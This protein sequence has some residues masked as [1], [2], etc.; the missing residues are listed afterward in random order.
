MSYIK[1]NKID[2]LGN[3]KI[4]YDYSIS[5]DLKKYFNLK[6]EYFIDYF[7]DIS[8]IPKAILTVP[9]IL[10]IIPLIW[11]TNS[12]LIID[13]IDETFYESIPSIKK[14][15][16][17]M[18]ENVEFKG[19]I[20]VNKIVNCNYKPTNRTATFFSGGLDS[21]STM[22]N[23]LD[24]KPDLVTLWGSDIDLEDIEGWNKVYQELK[25]IAQ[26][27][28]LKNVFIKSSFRK[29]INEGEL[30][31]S[32][33]NIL[34][35]N[36]WY[37]M[38]CGVGIIGH[39]APYAWKYKLSTQYIASS[40]CI[41]DGKVRSGSYPTIDNA[42]KFGSC[43]VYHD[44]FNYSRQDKTKYILK[45]CISKN[46]K[47]NLRVCWKST[48]GYNCCQCE[49]CYRTIFAILVEGN[50]P[51]DFGFDISKRDLKKIK[52][53]IQYTDLLLN[54][55][56]NKSWDEI[57]RAA[58]ENKEL[59]KSKLYYKDIKWIYNY[60]FINITDNWKY[61]L[62]YLKIILKGLISKGGV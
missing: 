8:T 55:N 43:N 49:K 54:S 4:V 12:D 14:G 19:N 18:Y 27:Y 29:I 21:H 20:K 46:I 58:L 39:I 28:E 53:H 47:I 42:V 31:K 60:N 22:F 32:F 62:Y 16:I 59:L 37:G 45:E 56:T 13:E 33:Y 38:Q 34:H 50:N 23:H 25:E 5:N 30:Y 36:W 48:G 61:K 35:V 57:K 1:L 2:I 17:D 40:E 15:Y 52:N 3:S 10:N 6:E 26:S 11:I 44:Q 7:E 9:F 41:T 24:T 51:N